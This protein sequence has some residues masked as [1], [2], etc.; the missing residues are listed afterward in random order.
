MIVIVAVIVVVMY[1]S[2]GGHAQIPDKCFSFYGGPARRPIYWAAGA[3]PAAAN[4]VD[5]GAAANFFFESA[6]QA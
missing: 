4:E 2:L 6:S 3:G 5:P 1:G